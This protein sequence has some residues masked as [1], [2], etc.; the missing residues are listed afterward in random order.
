MSHMQ[1]HSLFLVPFG[2]DPEVFKSTGA[3]HLC[4]RALDQAFNYYCIAP[5]RCKTLSFPLQ[6]S[7][8]NSKIQH[9]ALLT[10]D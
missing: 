5:L 6:V 7:A 10:P 9:K 8:S 4:P 3:F 2:P 1:K